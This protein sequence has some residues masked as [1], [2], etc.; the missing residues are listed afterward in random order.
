MSDSGALAASLP[1]SSGSEAAIA[2]SRSG[3]L[4]QRP[5]ART[6]SRASQSGSACAHSV[7]LP[8]PRQT[9]MSP[10]V[11]ERCSIGTTSRSLST[12]ATEAWPVARIAS[13]SAA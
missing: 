11:A 4:T 6:G 5:P 10:D 2:G 1:R 7:L 9:T 3:K 13:A 8:A 12:L